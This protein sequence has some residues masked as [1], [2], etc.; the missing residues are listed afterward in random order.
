MY[1]VFRTSDEQPD[2]LYFVLIEYQYS[3]VFNTLPNT[4][5][6]IFYSGFD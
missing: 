2:V 6:T 4:E 5:Y 1:S 3:F